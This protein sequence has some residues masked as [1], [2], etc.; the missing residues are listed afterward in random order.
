MQAS[1]WVASVIA[2]CAVVVAGSAAFIAWLQYR[3]SVES[4]TIR[5]DFHHAWALD[6]GDERWIA[7][8]CRSTSA[9]VHA[10]ATP[11]GYAEAEFGK[12]LSESS[13]TVDSEPGHITFG[14]VKFVRVHNVADKDG[15]Y[16]DLLA[17][18]DARGIKRTI[19]SPWIPYNRDPVKN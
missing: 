14:G 8:T 3:A 11:D 6:T 5:F 16:V 17:S 13:A 19:S 15:F 2:I 7:F 4:G 1:D 18:V 9:Y 12:P 10:V